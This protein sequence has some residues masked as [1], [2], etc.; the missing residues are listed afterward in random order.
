MF[1]VPLVQLL[2][3]EGKAIPVVVSKV[4][5]H[6]EKEGKTFYTHCSDNTYAATYDVFSTSLASSHY[7]KITL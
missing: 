5:E 1:A 4:V 7:G 3:Q 6:I 2:A